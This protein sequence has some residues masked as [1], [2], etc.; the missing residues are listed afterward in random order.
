MGT[1]SINGPF[2]MAMLNNRRVYPHQIM[3]FDHP[4]DQQLQQLPILLVKILVPLNNMASNQGWDLSYSPLNSGIFKLAPCL[5]SV[6]GIP[7]LLCQVGFI[8]H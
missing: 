4:Q 6:S 2:S 1:S 3:D 5:I 7:F 8:Y